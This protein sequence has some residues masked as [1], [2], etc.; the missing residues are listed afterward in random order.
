MAT[1]GLIL[2]ILGMATTLGLEIINYIKKD[3]RDYNQ[4]AY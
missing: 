3:N 2:F 4:N 1:A